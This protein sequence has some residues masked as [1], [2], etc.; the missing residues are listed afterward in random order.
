MP[1]SIWLAALAIASALP[2]AW[3]ATGNARV[4]AETRARAN[5]GAGVRKVTD[6]REVMLQQSTGDRV[7]RPAT[8]AI[9]RQV[10]RITPAGYAETLDRR[11]QMSGYG[12]RWT[13]EQMLAAKA[14]AACGGFFLGLVF[15]ISQPSML[16]FVLFIGLGAAFSFIPDIIL[17]NRADDRQAEIERALADSLDQ[18]TVCVEA[19]LSFESAL[20][21][22]AASKGP[23][24]DEFG[25]LLQDIQIGIPRERALESLLSRTDVSDLRVFVNA[26]N[27]AERYGIPIAHVLRVQ[28]TELREKRKQRAEER[29]LKMPVK[30]V[31]P[32]VVCILPALFIVVAGPAAVRMSQIF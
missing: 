14:G 2:L 6:L 17:S 24:A 3:W 20:S 11:L 19:G 28:A 16:R 18:I 4:A 21:R 31:F 23:L 7:V 32:V 26:M 5:L 25:R 30:L 10:R 9:A 12:E 8:D 13:I 15:W 29:A 1:L 27:H 22:V